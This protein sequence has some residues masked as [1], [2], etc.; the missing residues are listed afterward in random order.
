MK[1][2]VINEDIWDFFH[3]IYN[4]FKAHHPTTLFEYKPS[5]LPVFNNRLNRIRLL[6]KLN[7]FMQTHDVLFVEWASPYLEIIS[8]LPKTC[9]I[10]V[11]MHR[12]DIYKWMD[13]VNW[14]VVD[15][16]ILVSQAKRQEFSQKFPNQAHKI[17]VFPEA[18]S[19]ERFKPV[20]KP[21]CGN[22]GIL[23]HLTPRKRV[24]DLIL[25]FYELVKKRPGLHLHIGGEM[26]P[27]YQDYYHA[28]HRLVD[29]L[30]LRDCVS[31][32]GYV[33]KPETWYSKIDIF[34]SNSYSEGLQVSPM[35]AVASGCY[36]LSHH[37]DGAEELLPEEFLYY[38]N[39]ELQDKILDYYDLP[40][41]ERKQQQMLQIDLVREKFN[42]DLIKQQIRFLV[43]DVAK[44]NEYEKVE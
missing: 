25:T 29:K 6:R 37:W 17:V 33:E 31:F 38:T 30:N 42:V 16:I 14:D 1:I 19:C 23:C 20:S 43:E 39:T 36:T 7:Q 15:K 12:Y 18:I 27:A 3:D 10:V 11:R 8:H 9:G 13:K 44:F 41:M 40:D 26:R 4:E 2:G 24:Y 5:S 32:D 21:F 35:E 28:L 22:L 34:I